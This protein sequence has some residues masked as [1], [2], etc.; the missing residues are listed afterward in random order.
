MKNTMPRILIEAVVRRAL[1][2][3]GDSPERSTRN[4]VDMAL[5]F[6]QG[7]FQHR[8]FETARLMLKK[9]ESAFH[10]MVPDA[11]ASIDQERLIG[12][13]MNLGYNGCIAGAKIIRSIE[14][15]EHFNIPWMITLVINGD[16]CLNRA[17]DYCAILEQGRPLGIYTWQIYACGQAQKIMPLIGK[18]PDYAFILYCA[19]GEITDALLDEAESLHNLMIAVAYTQGADDACQLLRQR[20]FLYSVYVPYG[21]CD[22]PRI[23]SG[24]VLDDTEILHPVFTAFLADA[25]CPKAVREQVY[26]YVSRT[27]TQQLYKTVPWDAVSDS[28]FVNGVIS[29]DTCQA[30]FDG[31]GNL[32][33]FREGPER[34]DYNIFRQ[35]LREILK[36]AFPKET[37]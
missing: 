17:E 25:G 21:E 20:R 27:R 11:V 33:M 12:F 14:K 9:E 10:K 26:Q 31:Q 18:Y 36:Q 1:K 16:D 22:L 2:D 8:F 24:E 7:K 34:M 30:C 28:R 37:P 4:L 15:K 6:T 32:W 35:P 29:E 13:G 3:A 23:V 19:P 5:Q